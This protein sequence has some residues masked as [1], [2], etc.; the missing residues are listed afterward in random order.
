MKK[1]KK[2]KRFLAILLTCAMVLQSAGFSVL[3]EE[4]QQTEAQS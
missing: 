1:S 2:L 3:A 4:L